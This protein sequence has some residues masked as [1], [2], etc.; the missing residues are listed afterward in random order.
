A[1][2]ALVRLTLRVVRSKSRMPSAVSSCAIPV[3]SD[4]CTTCKRSAARVKLSSSATVTKY[5]SW[6]TSGCTPMTVPAV[7]DALGRVLGDPS[8]VPA[9]DALDREIETQPPPPPHAVDRAERLVSSGE[10]VVLSVS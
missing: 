6:R 1:A 7:A 3:L 10:P 9:A 4:C 8:F 5:C 2:P